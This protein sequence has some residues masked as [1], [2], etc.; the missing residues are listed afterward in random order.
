MAKGRIKAG[1]LKAHEK[2]LML[3]LSGEPI[4]KTEI[5]GKHKELFEYRMSSYILNNK[6]FFDAVVKVHKDGKKV[7]AYQLMNV[8]QVKQ[9]MIQKG[10]LKEQI[11]KIEDLGAKPVVKEQDTVSV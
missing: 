11:Q 2:V 6:I 10:I 5:M 9:K 3:M 1:E 4:T 8:D 7:T